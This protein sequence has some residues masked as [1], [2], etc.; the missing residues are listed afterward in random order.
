MLLKA[1]GV[2]VQVWPFESVISSRVALKKPLIVEERTQGPIRSGNKDRIGCLRPKFQMLQN[3]RFAGAAV[4][5]T[6][7]NKQ[8]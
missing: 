7:D 5:C 1:A 8:Q 2:G 6:T 4:V 3:T